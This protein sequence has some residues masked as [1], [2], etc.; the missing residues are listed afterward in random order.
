MNVA[1]SKPKVYHV[2]PLRLWLA[3]G[4]FMSLG[5]F[6]LAVAIF[7]YPNPDTNPYIYVGIGLLVFGLGMY[8]LIRH[9]RLVLSADGIRLQQFG[10]KLDTEWDNIS[11]L[12]DEPGAE[13][14]VLHRPMDCRGAFKLAALRN[15]QIEGASMYSAEQIQFIGEHRFIPLSPFAYWINKGDLH[16]DLLQRAPTMASLKKSDLVKTSTWY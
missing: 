7:N 3:P 14:L 6:A 9:T 8:L 5:I 1:T 4:I 11:H 12:Y 2:S 13:G 10:W 15:T 16:D